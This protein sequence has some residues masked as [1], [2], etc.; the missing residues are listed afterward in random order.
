MGGKFEENFGLGSDFQQFHD[1]F[2]LF[3]VRSQASA[4]LAYERQLGASQQ[5]QA[6]REKMFDRLVG[7]QQPYLTAGGEAAGIQA[8]LIGAMG[9]EAQQQ[10]MQNMQQSPGYQFR[11]KE[12]V[13]NINQNM[14]AQGQLL[15]G[16][17]L[18]AIQQ[19]GTQTAQDEFAN[20]VQR[21]AAV[22]GLGQK[23]ASAVGGVGQSVSSG[24]ASDIMAGGQAGAQSVLAAQQAQAQKTG[25]A[26]GLI[27]SVV[28]MFMSDERL[29]EDIF[30]VG[31]F[32]GLNVYTWKWNDE[33]NQIGLEGHAVGHIAQ[34]VQQ[35]Y[36]ELV[37]EKDG[38]LQVIYGEPGKTMEPLYG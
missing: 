26:A 34:E 25:D 11:L 2:D 36:P 31:K 12:G 6:F 21:L 1:P 30:K 4:D 3:G 5:A 9:P 10:A 14:A 28:G 22:S 24:I 18:K 16:N 13:K 8:A 32:N 38:Y 20:Q 17:R 35:R 19:F 15:G 37:R 23:A 33:A 29:K 7:L 27:G